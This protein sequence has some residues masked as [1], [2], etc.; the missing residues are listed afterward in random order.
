MAYLDSV[1][2][3]V[4]TNNYVFLRF[5]FSTS[6]SGRIVKKVETMTFMM[7]LYPESSGMRVIYEL[8]YLV[9]TML[10]VYLTLSAWL[11]SWLELE[12]LVSE[13]H[14]SVH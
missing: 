3:D 5:M 9:F 8:I 1:H 11:V 14:S 6:N 12:Y 2:Y 13:L 10:T 4:N 7:D